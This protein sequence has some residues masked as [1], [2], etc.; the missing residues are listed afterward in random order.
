MFTIIF[1]VN[2]SI[3]VYDGEYDKYS[4]SEFTIDFDN[5]GEV[6]SLMMK[7]YDFMPSFYLNTLDDR[8][9]DGGGIEFLLSH[10]ILKDK[11]EDE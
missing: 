3:Q 1:F 9:I 7:D 4:K 5:E 6:T 10:N 11:G 8:L 2:Y